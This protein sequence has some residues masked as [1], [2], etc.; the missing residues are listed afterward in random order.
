[1]LG[2]I[3]VKFKT[4][5]C[6]FCMIRYSQ[7]GEMLKKARTT[8][9]APAVLAIIV[10]LA[11]YLRTLSFDFVNLDD[12]FY[13][14]DNPAIKILDWQF[15]AEAFITSYMGWWMPLTWISFAVDHFFWGLNPV[16]YHL[17][18]ALLHALN[19][20]LVVLIADRLLRGERRGLKNQVSGLKGEY[21]LSSVQW[22]Y[23]VL[24]L[25]GLLWGLHPLR[26]ESVAWVTERKDVLSGFF[27]L[28]S[29]LFYLKYVQAHMATGSRQRRD[30][31][32]SLGFLVLAMM[33]KPVSV[34]IPA[35]LLV[36]DWYPL[37]RMRAGNIR[38]VLVEK[39]PLFI[40]GGAVAAATIYFAAGETIL[41]SFD[42]FP[43]HRRLLVAGNALA[44][45]V[46]MSVF[47]VGLT[48][49]YL[50]PREFPTS[51][52]VNSLL[53]LLVT[54]WCLYD[55]RKRPYLLAV[56]LLFLLPLIPVLGIFQNGAQSHADRFTYL[57]A[58]A[59]SIAI[60]AVLAGWYQ[61]ATNDRSRLLIA[62]FAAGGL[63]VYGIASYQ[64]LGAW[65]DS[66]TLWTRLI[67]VRPVGRAYYYRGEHYLKKGNYPAA[68]DDLQISIRMAEGAGNPE[69]LNLY[70]LRGY[71]LYNAGRL[72][73]AVQDYSTAI[74]RYP[75]PNFYYHRGVA[76]QALGRTP[77][78]NEDFIR[79]GGASGPIEWRRMW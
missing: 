19:A 37:G 16:G 45:Y 68:I 65:K 38:A 40:M 54:C 25:A 53:S 62:V 7:T 4:I 3:D 13:V 10:C 55:V 77:E 6:G 1:V 71:A 75:E 32:L 34:V 43:L 61:R 42:V 18:N 76:L 20:G 11:I 12:P 52:Y 72:V 2:Y 73:E 8:V 39:I 51:Y 15:V 33:A 64:L 14:Y 63:L 66:E 44:E 58:V 5:I 17:T 30:Y 67:K 70:A 31:L 49:L 74:A 36:V 29:V 59:P 47:P 56:W 23:A 26:V 60:A 46:R 78:A 22:Y 27:S 41:V 50:L 79:A 24:L 57:P 9:A 35:M 28:G 69:V 48:H 21:Q